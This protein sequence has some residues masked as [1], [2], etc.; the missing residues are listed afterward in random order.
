MI[1]NYDEYIINESLI[2]E[3]LSFNDIKSKV[4]NFK[5]KNKALDYLINKFNIVSDLKLKSKISKFIILTFMMTLSNNVSLNLSANQIDD[6]SMQ[7]NN[8]QTLSKEKIE[9][10]LYDIIGHNKKIVKI[11]DEIINKINKIKPN[12]LSKRKKDKYNKEDT[13][14]IKALHD[15]ERIGEKPDY[16]LIKCIMIIETGMEPR[17]N[18][19]GFHGYPQTKQKY[20]DWINKKNNTNFTL[21]DM[22]DVY[23]SAQYIHYYVKTLLNSSYINNNED[24]VI[25]YNWGIGNLRLYKQGEKELPKESEDYVNMLNIIY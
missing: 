23:K 13:K 21:E 16:N 10:Q 2:T 7:I 17:E 15:L 5:N 18:H 19:L 14:I 25:A 3:E 6:V 22:Y 12:I 20:I 11:N 9:K 4:M 24:I 1:Y 8:F